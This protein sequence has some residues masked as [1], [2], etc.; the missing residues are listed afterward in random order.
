M[1]NVSLD[2]SFD[3]MRGWKGMLEKAGEVNNTKVYDK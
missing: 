3:N 1:L 2:A